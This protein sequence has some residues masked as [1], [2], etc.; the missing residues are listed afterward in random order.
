MLSLYSLN[1]NGIRAAHNT[2]FLDWLH[3]TR[4]DILATQETK[5]RPD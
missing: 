4:P 3:Q 1:V 2:G 5:T